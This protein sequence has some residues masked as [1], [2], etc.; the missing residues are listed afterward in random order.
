MKLSLVYKTLV[1]V[2]A[3]TVLFIQKKA[4][5]HLRYNRFLWPVRLILVNHTFVAS[6]IK[7]F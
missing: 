6:V 5:A 7:I 4:I 3:G 2:A 1:A